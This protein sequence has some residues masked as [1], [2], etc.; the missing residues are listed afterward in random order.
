MAENKDLAGKVAIGTST[1]S[2]SHRPNT[3][4]PKKTVTG[5]SRGIGA[6]IALKLAQHGANIA[7]NYLTPSSSKKAKEIARQI[8]TTHNVRAITIQADVSQEHEVAAMFETVMR[9]F[10]RLDIAVSNAGIEHFGALDRDTGEDIDRVFAVNVK[11]QYFV[12]QRAYKC[13][14]EYGRVM[15]TSSIS[16]V[17]V[18]LSTTIIMSLFR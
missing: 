15:L 7:L 3:H 17:K 16:A 11:G 2:P 18:S 5:S 10:G 6:A 12:A 13:M 14:E 9:E 1:L 4:N 8:R